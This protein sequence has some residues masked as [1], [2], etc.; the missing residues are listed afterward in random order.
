MLLLEASETSVIHIFFALIFRADGASNI[1][2]LQPSPPS[3]ARNEE[4]QPL[5]RAA[6]AMPPWKTI[7][8]TR[9]LIEHRFP[10]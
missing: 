9:L 3:V 6:S 5:R 10:A 8:T 4:Q 7:R 1:H 2:I